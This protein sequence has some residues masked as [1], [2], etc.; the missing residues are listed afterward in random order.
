[1][2]EL[3]Y[4]IPTDNELREYFLEHFD[5]TVK[6]EMFAPL[7][8]AEGQDLRAGCDRL[9]KKA[10]ESIFASLQR[11][12]RLERADPFW[13][14]TNRRPT[15]YKLGEFCDVALKENPEDVLAL[16]TKLALSVV[17]GDY[18]LFGLE[19]WRRLQATSELEAEDLICAELY[20][21][22]ACGCGTASRAAGLLRELGLSDEAKSVLETGRRS[23]D[24]VIVNWCESVLVNL[25]EV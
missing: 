10:G 23:A 25:S 12:N 17:W 21:E 13:R 15:V 5:F 22:L 24:E 11:L 18:G 2:P 3:K 8:R 16:R 1:M 9:I 20:I 14:G 6:G 4:E 19:Q 7:A